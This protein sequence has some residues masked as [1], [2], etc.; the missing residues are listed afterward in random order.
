M[1]F[2]M[3]LRDPSWHKKLIGNQQFSV[4]QFAVKIQNLFFLD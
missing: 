2:A 3:F 4:G 1:P